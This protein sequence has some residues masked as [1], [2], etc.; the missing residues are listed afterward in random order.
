MDIIEFSAWN[1]RVSESNNWLTT[2]PLLKRTGSGLGEV[3]VRVSNVSK[4]GGVE[5]GKDYQT[6]GSY[7][8]I[9][10]KDGDLSN[11]EIII[12][13]LDDSIVE[14]EEVIPLKL[15]TPV[16]CSLGEMNKSSV[17]IVD[18]DYNPVSNVSPYIYSLDYEITIDESYHN[19][20]LEIDADCKII[21]PTLNKFCQFRI[22]LLSSTSTITFE[23]N[24][25]LA[26]G[27]KAKTPLSLTLCEYNPDRNKWYLFGLLDN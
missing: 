19:K 9:T 18:N 14:N 2:K 21:L 5:R 23:G 3:S 1:Y 24:N 17:I 4:K 11:K 7:Q 13:I 16:N 15:S 10:W 25:I 26:E 27:I 8:V 12:T 6:P 20:T 22:I